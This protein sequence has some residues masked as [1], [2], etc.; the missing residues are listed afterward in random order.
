MAI[1]SAFYFVVEWIT[2]ADFLR[3]EIIRLSEVQAI[4]FRCRSS[5]REVPFL[6]FFFF[7]QAPD[8]DGR[9]DLQGV[10]DLH[11]AR[12]DQFVLAVVVF[13]AAGDLLRSVEPVEAQPDVLGVRAADLEDACHAGNLEVRVEGMEGFGERLRA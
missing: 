7:F 4:F 5:S 11:V 1:T 13:P 12:C 6:F 3:D 8:L 9:R 2:Y 10:D